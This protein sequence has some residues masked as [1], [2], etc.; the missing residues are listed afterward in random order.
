MENEKK[1]GKGRRKRER[2]LRLNRVPIRK[3]LEIRC[4]IFALTKIP[5]VLSHSL[6]LTLFYTH[7]LAH[8]LSLSHTHTHTVFSLVLWPKKNKRLFLLKK[9]WL[10]L[11][12]PSKQLN[13]IL[14]VWQLLLSTY[15]SV[16]LDHL[17]R[18]PSPL[19]ELRDVGICLL[20]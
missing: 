10:L 1:R 8:K 7:F 19:C 2:E 16:F 17:F 13:K 20:D 3:D 4:E 12:A 6:V 11:V 9:K 15:K 5:L 18:H 14:G